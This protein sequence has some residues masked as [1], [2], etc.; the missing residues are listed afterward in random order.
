MSRRQRGFTLLEVLIA[1]AIVGTLLVIA[2]GGLRVALGAWRRG[3]E[4]AEVHQHVRGVALLLA[5]AVGGAYPYVAP[6]GAAPEPVLLF[7]G[8]ERRLELVTQTTPFPFARPIAFTAMVIALDEDR[9]HPGLV[10]RQ[11]ALP[12]REPFAAAERVFH[13]PGVTRL[14]FQYLDA[15]G[16]WQT[17]WDGPAQQAPPRAVRIAVGTTVGGQERTLPPLTVSLRVGGP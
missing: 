4:R 17:T 1:L 7:V 2:V 6:R 14:A 10:I 11:R 9:E 8:G 5:R 3:E 12:N 15:S 16:A 13:D